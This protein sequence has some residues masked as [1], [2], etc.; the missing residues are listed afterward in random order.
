MKKFIDRLIINYC[1]NH[2]KQF[3]KRIQKRILKTAFL[4][5]HRHSYMCIAISESINLIYGINTVYTDFSSFIPIFHRSN[6]ACFTGIKT[7]TGD[8]SNPWCES[9]Y[10]MPRM[11]FLKWCIENVY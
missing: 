2:E 10:K 8:L 6:F 5:L 11:K 9:H 1:L 4:H 3:P 7:Y